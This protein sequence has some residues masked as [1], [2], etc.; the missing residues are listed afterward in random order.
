MK[1]AGESFENDKMRDGCVAELVSRNQQQR[2]IFLKLKI[3]KE[4]TTY[5]IEREEGH[6]SLTEAMQDRERMKRSGPKCVCFLR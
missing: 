4:D 5:G 1:E 2:S 6:K 3:W